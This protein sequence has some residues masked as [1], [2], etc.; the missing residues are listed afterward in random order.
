[1]CLCRAGGRGRAVGH[2][3]AGVL[4]RMV[5][6]SWDLGN[7]CRVSTRLPPNVSLAAGEFYGGSALSQGNY[8]RTVTVTPG[9]GTKKLH[10]PD[11]REAERP[12]FTRLQTPQ[13]TTASAQRLPTHMP[14]PLSLRAA[15]PISAA[16]ATRPDT[17]PGFPAPSRPGRVPAGTH[18]VGTLL[19]RHCAQ[20]H[21]T[22]CS[23]AAALPPLPAATPPLV[24]TAGS[25][26][27]TEPKK[28]PL[29][30]RPGSLSRTAHASR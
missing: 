26:R 2:C 30:P 16:A 3:G 15:P 13:T 23:R 18:P 8:C 21:S 29:N 9:W 22:S 1:M 20:R 17:R 24:P 28:A 7:G 27:D 4:F 5:R 6:S 19:P 14:A 12:T 11:L 25:R 10:S